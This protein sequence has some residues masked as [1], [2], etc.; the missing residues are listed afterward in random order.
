MAGLQLMQD[1]W[2]RVGQRIIALGGTTLFLLVVAAFL[3]GSAYV[4]GVL[5]TTLARQTGNN[6]IYSGHF[7]TPTVIVSQSWEWTGAIVALGVLA[8]LVALLRGRQRGG[9]T[10]MLT[11]LVFAGLLVTLGNI[12]LHTDQSMNKHDDFGMWFACIPAAYALAYLADVARTWRMKIPVLAFAAI[13]TVV[14]GYHYSQP[15]QL[16]TYFSLQTLS[17]YENS[18][19]TF[20]G[21]YLKRGNEE[22]ILASKLDA[23]MVYDNSSVFRRHLSQVSHSRPRR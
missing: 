20:L 22:Y 2:R 23:E 13:V 4:S 9:H 19:Y 7:T 18:T 8:L 11:F 3:A 14:S 6:T 12:R 5:V 21:P 10:V 1:R 17:A 15:S 16:D